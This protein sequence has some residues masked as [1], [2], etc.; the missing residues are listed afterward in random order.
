MTHQNQQNIFRIL[1]PNKVFIFQYQGGRSTILYIMK[2]T[3]YGFTF[4]IHNQASGKTWMM[5]T[6][7][8]DVYVSIYNIP[9]HSVR[10]CALTVKEERKIHS[11]YYWSLLWTF[12]KV[13]ADNIVEERRPE[14]F[15]PAATRNLSHH[16]Q[17]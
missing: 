13:L 17:Q 8:A 5:K 1:Y 11:R 4:S 15:F 3:I 2:N 12:Q 7:F 10:K 14:I 9:L 16:H 6:F